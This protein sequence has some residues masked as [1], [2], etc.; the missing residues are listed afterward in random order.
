MSVFGSSGSAKQSPC[1]WSPVICSL[2]VVD[3]PDAAYWACSCN[4]VLVA[5][6]RTCTQQRQSEPH[7]RNEPRTVSSP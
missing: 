2:V 3:S 6:R 7:P 1:D 5:D 4:P